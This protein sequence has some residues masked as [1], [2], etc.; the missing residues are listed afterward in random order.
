[1]HDITFSEK[2]RQVAHDCGANEELIIGA[3]NL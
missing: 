2:I 3:D 1:M